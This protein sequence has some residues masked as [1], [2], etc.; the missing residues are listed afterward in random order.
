MNKDLVTLLSTFKSKGSVMVLTGAGISAES[1]IPTFRGKEG[2]WVI[3]SRN[4]HP[5]EMAT[6]GMFSQKPEEVWKWYL[7]RKKICN[8]AEPNQGHIAI[9][10]L[11]ESLKDRFLLITQ[12]V[13]GLHKRAGNKNIYEIHGNIDYM[14][15]EATGEV[16]KIPEGLTDRGDKDDLKEEEKKLLKNPKT[17]NLCR[18]HILW[19]DESYN[20]EYYK[21]ESSL[22][23][24]EKLDLL[25]VI[26]T[27]GA[28]TLPY[29]II[30]AA[31]MAGKP[32]IAVDPYE[33]D[34]TA[35]AERYGYY[36]SHK[37]GEILPK[38]VNTII[39]GDISG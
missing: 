23:A 29:R 21:F 33:N 9:R 20:E 3:R 17:G 1:G 4:Y 18:P 22:A 16:L 35:I 26:G 10:D 6:Y 15:D 32:V 27:T 5:Q 39:R 24:L 31:T 11:E 7:Y 36:L 8:R 2:Y 38:I 13:D 30:T 34:V 12:N 14:R 25:I 28:T 19:F 37:S